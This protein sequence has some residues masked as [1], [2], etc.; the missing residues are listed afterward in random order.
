M[1]Q[2]NQYEDELL[3][4]KKEAEAA[5]RA[6]DEFLSTVSHELRTP[7]GSIIGWAQ[8]LQHSPMDDQSAKHALEV[9]LRNAKAQSQLIE[10]LLDFAGI[11]SG[12]LRL[13]VSQINPQ[14]VVEAAIDIV[15][16][17]AT[18]KGI[19]LRIT[20]DSDRFV[21]GNFERLQQ[22]MWNLLSNA[23]KFTPPGGRV[24]VKSEIR[25][26]NIEISITDTGKGISED[27]LPFV[28]ERFRQGDDAASRRR[29]GG[30]GLG[31]AI[32]KH[33]VEL[34]GGTIRAESPG[35]DLGAIFTVSLP[36]VRS[37]RKETST[38]N[39]KKQS[40][41]EESKN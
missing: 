5:T 11:V 41:F 36:A 1:R 28:F 12:K 10:D 13:D 38:A 24:R 16:P 7:I 19:D 8:I 31:L 29:R 3:R 20:L 22:V 6:K 33:I 37:S 15:T 21:S 4:A 25:D 30:L 26:S 40:S 2:R 18:A 14:K 35:E 9:I 27:F 39:Y 17:A 32:S 34:H 23:I